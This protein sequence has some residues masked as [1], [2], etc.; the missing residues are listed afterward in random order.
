MNA[1]AFIPLGIFICMAALFAVPLLQGK[2]PAILPSAMIGKPVPVFTLPAAVG[3]KT[4]TTAV[5]REDNRPF[6]VNFFASWCVTCKG[7][8]RVLA[9]FSR[10][11]NIPVY[12][13]DYK[14]TR[15]DVAA[16]LERHGNPFAA[17]GFD[18]EGRVAIDF[19]VYGVPETFLVDGQ[20]IIR[21]KHV[22]ALKK[23][24]M[25]TIFTPLLE[26]LK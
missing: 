14:D 20:G 13:I 1:R 22:G 2:D 8:Q 15:N 4:L 23:E 21:Y 6:L 11:H 9:D 10:Q 19:G 26:K 16:W 12:G 3:Q 24:D 17:T 18:A 25:D 7:E 5:M